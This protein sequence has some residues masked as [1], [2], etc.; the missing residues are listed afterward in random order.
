MKAIIEHVRNKKRKRFLFHGLVNNYI[1]PNNENN[2]PPLI[3]RGQ[4]PKVFPDIPIGPN[5]NGLLYLSSTRISERLEGI[6]GTHHF[7]HTSIKIV[8]N[9]A[10]TYSFYFIFI[11]YRTVQKKCKRKSVFFVLCSRQNSTKFHHEISSKLS[12]IFVESN[13]ISLLSW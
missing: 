1:Y 11:F 9:S 12:Q 10:W 4:L 8:R 3:L 2:P 7:F 5:R 6:K 13:E